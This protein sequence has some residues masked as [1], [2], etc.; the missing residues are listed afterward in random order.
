MPDDPSAASPSRKSDRK[1]KARD[2]SDDEAPAA[3][4]PQAS[5]RR[6]ADDNAVALL[7]AA[8]DFRSRT[9]S[10]PLPSH[11]PAFYDSAKASLPT[12]LTKDQVYNKLR[13][14]RQKFQK[15]GPPGSGP[16]DGLV[17]ELCTELWGAEDNKDVNKDQK[18]ASKGTLVVAVENGVA[19][20]EEEEPEEEGDGEER[21]GG[22]P[23][24]LPYVSSAVAEH[25]K[26][27]GTCGVSWEVGLKR[28][29]SSKARSLEEKWRR[30]LGDEMRLQ[31]DWCKTNREILAL[32][33][34][35]YKGMSA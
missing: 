10:I 18:K 2:F 32:L 34:D 8:I 21:E 29:D 33:N 19:A 14:L 12:P 5:Q 17:H 9:G 15:A 6:L 24:S 11:M 7:R 30:Q 28:M 35:A 4:S 27:N 23:D 22:G 1:R 20:D 16:N 26:A 13:H 3:K 31:M 25:W